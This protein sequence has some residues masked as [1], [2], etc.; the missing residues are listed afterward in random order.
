M[1]FIKLLLGNERKF[2]K[3]WIITASS[4]ISNKERYTSQD[5]RKH[6]TTIGKVVTKNNIKGNNALGKMGVDSSK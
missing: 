6:G 1:F 4:R 5:P 2:Y 3:K